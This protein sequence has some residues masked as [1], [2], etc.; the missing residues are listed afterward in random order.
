MR[1]ALAEVGLLRE[2]LEQ[3]NAYLK[4]EIR[5]AR[6]HEGIIGASPATEATLRRSISSRARTPR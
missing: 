6:H 4:E 5:A 1:S 3:E 2:R